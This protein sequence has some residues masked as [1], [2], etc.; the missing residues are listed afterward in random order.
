MRPWSIVWII[1]GGLAAVGAL[2]QGDTGAAVFLGS[3]A[4]IVVGL[5]A[6]RTRRRERLAAKTPRSLFAT[7]VLRTS[8]IAVASVVLFVLAIF[9]PEGERQPFLVF[10]SLAFLWAA[11]ISYYLVTGYQSMKRIEKSASEAE[12]EVEVE[13][14]HPEPD[15][16]PRLESGEEPNQD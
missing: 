8:V 6:T 3:M 4:L 7:S 16:G 13:R 10:G 1:I 14:E 15:S 11:V 5:E 12:V 9:A 2:T